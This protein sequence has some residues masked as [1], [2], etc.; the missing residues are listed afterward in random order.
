MDLKH[1]CETNA[2]SPVSRCVCGESA[3]FVGLLLPLGFVLAFGVLLF[4]SLVSTSIS[5]AIEADRLM[6]L[7]VA[8]SPIGYIVGAILSIVALLKF[9]M[10]VTA[11]TAV[12]V[13]LSMLAF[14]VYFAQ[15]F[16]VEFRIVGWL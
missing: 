1:P 12:V 9:D 11:C 13:N 7:L 14:L 2:E 3:A 16:L 8:L 6:L 10:R 5:S 4:L 15:S